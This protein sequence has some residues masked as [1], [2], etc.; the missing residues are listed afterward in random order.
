MATTASWVPWHVLMGLAPTVAAVLTTLTEATSASAPQGTQGSTVRR[1]LTTAPPA[2]APMVRETGLSSLCN[3]IQFVFI[4]GDVSIAFSV[5]WTPKIRSGMSFQRLDQTFMPLLV[6]SQV[7]VVWILS[8]RI[9]VSVQ[10]VSPVWTVTTLGTS[11]QRTLAKMVGHARKVLTATPAPAHRDTPV[12]TAAHPLAAVNTTLATTVPPA[13]R[14]T[15]AMSVHVFLATVAETVN[16]CFQSTLLSVGQRCPGWP[17]GPV[18][19]WCC[20]CWQ[21]ALYLLDFSDQKPSVAVK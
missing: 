1:R 3:P 8:T 2:P 19:P 17:L 6:C 16:S 20:C 11:A 18:W 21:D 7:H 13:M 12:A 10:M 4:L 15:I 9:C 5:P 14:E